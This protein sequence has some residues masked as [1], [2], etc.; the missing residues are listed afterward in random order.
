MMVN[1]IREV[2]Q[3]FSKPV[4][5]V[6]IKDMENLPGENQE[7]FMIIDADESFSFEKKRKSMPSTQK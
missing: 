1:T 3:R 7:C 4:R 2:G 5:G 6:G